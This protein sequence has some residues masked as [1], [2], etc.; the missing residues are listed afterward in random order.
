MHAPETL[1]PARRWVRPLRRFVDDPAPGMSRVT[2]AGGLAVAGFW[3]SCLALGSP[4][5]SES[6]V[7]RAF[8]AAFP[9]ADAVLAIAL[10]A[11][12]RGL[13]RRRPWGA[14]A[15]TA[16]SA[17]TV[18]LGLVDVTF[19]V[20]QGLYSE[21]PGTLTAALAVQAFCLVGGGLGIWSGHRLWRRSPAPSA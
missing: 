19:S 18:Y 7:V 3:A 15:L 2:L 1:A 21:G 6:D 13:R 12:S 11:T 20:S 16:A 14:F 9:V 4:W 5:A 8:E 17:A 10:L